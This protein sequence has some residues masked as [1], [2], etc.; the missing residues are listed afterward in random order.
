M[1]RQRD[2]LGRLIGKKK[3][4]YNCKHCGKEF[5]YWASANRKFCSLE[6]Y[7]IFNRGKN[8]KFYGRHHTE[9][10]KRIFAENVKKRTEKQVS[11]KVIA[12]KRN[13]IVCKKDFLKRNTESWGNYK[14]RILCSTQC[15]AIW[16]N[17]K[18]PRTKKMYEFLCKQCGKD[19]KDDQKN[20]K[21]CSRICYNNW[22]KV[23]YK[24][25]KNPF[26]GKTHSK[27]L[28]DTIRAKNF[29]TPSNERVTG[30]CIICKKD[31]KK[32]ERESWKDYKKH[33]FCSKI[34]FSKYYCGK[35]CNF[36]KNGLANE[37]YT[38]EF[39]ITFKNLIR[40]RDNQICI[41]CGLHREKLKRSL[42][43]HHI[44]YDK[45]IS[46]PQNCLSLC[47]KCHILTN[48]NRKYWTRL[49]QEKLSRL[50]DYKYSE[51][52]K[53]IIDLNNCKEVN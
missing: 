25:E 26:W 36:W 7:W 37:P 8:N 3:G 29:K 10:N 41:N 32:S 42:D 18:F 17:S 46:I 9:E 31:I 28:I 48:F 23:V 27:Y 49:F 24:G 22:N 39:S 35:R 19:F 51:D 14:K 50:Y 33:K 43:V 40:K 34:C 5:R 53:I 44:N 11:E 4:V 20:R 1:E 13:C 16:K 47:L 2:K 6:C 30:Y 21:F 38:K 12:F 15:S 45:K 52:G